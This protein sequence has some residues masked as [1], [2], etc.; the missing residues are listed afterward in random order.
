MSCPDQER[1]RAAAHGAGRHPS[2]PPGGP[3]HLMCLLLRVIY[4]S[5]SFMFFVSGGWELKHDSKLRGQRHR[6]LHDPI[7]RCFLHSFKKKP[8]KTTIRALGPGSGP[9]S[10]AVKDLMVTG[11]NYVVIKSVLT[12]MTTF[13][14]KADVMTP[15]NI[16]N[17][18][19][20][21]HL[22]STL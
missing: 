8:A 21:P 16:S 10:V 17:H 1:A 7:V 22:T 6:A 14:T 12:I 9:L 15:F 19:C 5:T 18:T 2:G 13:Q 3:H 4:C 11:E 20:K